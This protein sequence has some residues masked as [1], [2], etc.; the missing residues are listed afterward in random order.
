ME[1]PQVEGASSPRFPR[2]LRARVLPIGTTTLSFS[3]GRLYRYP[4]SEPWEKTRRHSATP[5]RV[6]GIALLTDDPAFRIRRAI[7]EALFKP[8]NCRCRAD[9][10]AVFRQ[11]GETQAGPVKGRTA[12]RCREKAEVAA[13]APIAGKDEIRYEE[14]PSRSEPD[15]E[16]EKALPSTREERAASK[17]S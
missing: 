1:T 11:L 4:A 10:G 5:K 8:A 12:S 2:E 7:E 16:R 14:P 3:S 13:M 15:A 6:F 9:R 17:G